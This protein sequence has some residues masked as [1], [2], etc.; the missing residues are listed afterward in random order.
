MKNG[1]D[2]RSTEAPIA[3]G[4]SDP[5]KSSANANAGSPG[6]RLTRSIGVG[7]SGGAGVDSVSLTRAELEGILSKHVG[8]GRKFFWHVWPDGDLE[9][10]TVYL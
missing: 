10:V 1:E 8:G 2:A 5:G 7:A 9:R 3:M 4:E 6:G